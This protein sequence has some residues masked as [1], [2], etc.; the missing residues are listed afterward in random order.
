IESMVLITQNE[1]LDMEDVP[2]WIYEEEDFQEN[3]PSQ[4]NSNGLVI[5]PGYSMDDYERE[6]IRSTL[7]MTKGNRAEAAKIL[8]IG[9]RTLYRKLKKYNLS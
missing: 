7:E 5:T 1:I 9:E 3:S 4:Q 6:I 8:N 2:E